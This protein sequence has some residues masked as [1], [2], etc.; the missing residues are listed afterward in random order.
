MKFL[1]MILLIC[2]CSG[3][4][5]F[6]NHNLAKYSFDVWQN[7]Y[8]KGYDRGYNAGYFLGELKGERK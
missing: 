4:T 1:S 8:L 2:I 3:C 7:G 5:T 6:T